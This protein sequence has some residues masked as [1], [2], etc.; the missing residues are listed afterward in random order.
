MKKSFD[1]VAVFVAVAELGGFRAAA[2]HL[3]VTASA[4]S[5]AI[6]AL[7]GSIGTPLFARTTR[8]VH[9]T[10]AGQKLLSHARP[11]LA[12][13]GAGIAAASSANPESRCR[14]RVNASTDA[15]PLLAKHLFPDF[16]RIHP[17]IQLEFVS[18][19]D[20]VN[21][22]AT[23]DVAAQLTGYADV[24]MV[25]VSLTP[26][27]QLIVVGSLELLES[28]KPPAHP[29]D[30]TRWPCVL[31]NADSLDLRQ[32]RFLIEDRPVNVTVDGPLIAQDTRTAI[33]AAISGLGLLQLRRSLVEQE[34][35]SGALVA[36]LDDFAITVPGLSL[37]YQ[38]G[39]DTMPKLR[40]FVSFAAERFR[41]TYSSP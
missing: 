6:Q 15:L 27:D 17:T 24:D 4:V 34:L 38:V 10:N 18:E 30:L 2:R 13:L 20:P 22:M 33:N 5:Q 35:S 16:F 29:T 12:M 11:G 32:W 41:K 7:E 19:T 14:L 9:L 1:G 39:A 37:H 3:G 21:D 28:D 40:N 23:Y 36:V 31:H 26:S 25:A 8:S